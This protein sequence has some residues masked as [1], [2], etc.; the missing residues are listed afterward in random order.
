MKRLRILE[1]ITSE[2]KEERILTLSRKRMMKE[3]RKI[4]GS[5]RKRSR[6]H[7]RQLLHLCLHN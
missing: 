6:R 1:M 5:A 2:M 3:E 4:Y 7:S